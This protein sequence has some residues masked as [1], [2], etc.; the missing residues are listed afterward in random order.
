MRV[1]YKLV[2]TGYSYEWAVDLIKKWCMVEN[3]Y[4]CAGFLFSFII[5]DTKSL[6]CYAGKGKKMRK[7]ETRWVWEGVGIKKLAPEKKTGDII[8]VNLFYI[9]QM[10]AHIIRLILYWKFISYVCEIRV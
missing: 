3:F 2:S 9:F 1:L 10:L 7:G 4:F 6:L 5:L 8:Y